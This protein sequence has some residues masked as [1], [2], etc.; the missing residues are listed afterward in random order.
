MKQV[1][2]Y[3]YMDHVKGTCRSK[4]VENRVSTA[5]GKF[6]KKIPGQGE[7]Q[8]GCHMSGKSQGKLFFFKVRVMSMNFRNLSAKN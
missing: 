2:S 7:T 3:M 8:Q 6:P 4:S 1:S 5:Q